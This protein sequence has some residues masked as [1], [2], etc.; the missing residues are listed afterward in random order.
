MVASLKMDDILKEALSTLT[1][2]PTGKRGGGCINEGEAYLVDSGTVFVKRNKKSQARLMFDGELEGL[3]AI[4]AT[5]TVRV[6]QPVALVDTPR[7]GAALVLEYVD[8]CG[9]RGSSRQLGESLA[10]LHLH[11]AGLGE[12]FRGGAP[13]HEARFGFHVP[14]AACGYLP[15][16][17]TWSDDWPMIEKDYGDR[18]ALELWSELQL[19]VPS[20]FKDLEIKPALLHGDLW[21]GNAAENV[22]G[23]VIFDPASFYGHHEFELSISAMFGGFPTNFFSAYHKIIPKAPGFDT[24]QKLYQLFHYLNHWNHFGASYRG[25]TI[26][27]MKSLVK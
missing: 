3:R 8:M 26:S 24:R 4:A 2:I 13:A 15:L 11:N 20:F 25:S 17:N 5:R 12:A 19:K 14:R 21:G 23:P 9:L 27:I 6:P 22:E 16:D 1:L 7:G 10:R 18:E